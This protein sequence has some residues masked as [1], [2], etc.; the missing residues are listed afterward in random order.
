[1][2]GGDKGLS[3][4]TDVLT[5]LDKGYINFLGGVW[6]TRGAITRNEEI[7]QY[8]EDQL[9]LGGEGLDEHNYYLLEINL[10]NLENST[11]E[12]EQL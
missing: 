4:V 12:D 9:D 6:H 1:M 7:Q 2:Y 8:I 5:V 3:G 11:G 10:D